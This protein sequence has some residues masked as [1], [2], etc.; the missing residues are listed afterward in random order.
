MDTFCLYEHI[1]KIFHSIIFS[2]RNNCG[3]WVINTLR[4]KEDNEEVNPVSRLDI[5]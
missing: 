2:N 3:Q 5:E 4:V 1:S